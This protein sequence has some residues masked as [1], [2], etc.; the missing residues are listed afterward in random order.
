MGNQI[1]SIYTEA[2]PPGQ[3]VDFSILAAA[4]KNKERTLFTAKESGKVLA[5]AITTPLSGVH[6]HCLEYLAVHQGQRSRGVGSSL[7]RTMVGDLLT[8]EHI[9]GLIL[10]VESDQIDSEEERETRRARM[11]FYRRNGAHLVEGLAHFLAPD[12]IDG[13][14]IEMRLM[15]LPAGGAPARLS[16]P[17]LCAC[18]CG[19]YSQCYGLPPDDPRVGATLRSSDC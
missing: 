15:W 18:V 4:V 3:R 19:I 13:G 9:A 11:A 16:D 14:T 8:T 12:L 2:F 17:D 6:V 7:I 5:F 10:E 1:Q